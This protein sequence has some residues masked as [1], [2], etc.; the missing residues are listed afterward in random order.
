MALK[1]LSKSGIVTGQPVE[2]HHVSQSVE[3]LTGD[4]AFSLT[5]S[6]SL[7]QLGAT[8]TAVFTNASGSFSGSFQGNGSKLTDITAATAS[9]ITS[10]NIDGAVPSAS[11]ALTASLATR[12]IDADLALSAISATTAETA[13]FALNFPASPN[14]VKEEFTSSNSINVNH[15]L[16]SENVLVQ[17]YEASGSE[18]RLIN[19]S[20]VVIEDANNLRVELATNSTGYVVVGESGFL[21]SGSVQ[22]A[23][24]ASHLL[25]FIES[26]SFATTASFAEFARSVSGSIESASVAETASYAIT[27]S[28]ALNAGGAS[29]L[30]TVR[31]DFTGSTNI[32]VNHSLGTTNVFVQT[33]EDYGSEH[34]LLTPSNV[35][36]QDNNNV[37]VELASPTT[38]YIVVGESGYVTSGSIVNA[39][40]A[41][42]VANV[43]RDTLSGDGGYNVIHNLNE[44]YVLVQTYDTVNRRVI[45]PDIIESINS[46][47]T[48]IQFAATSSVAVVIKK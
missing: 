28:Y 24:T 21:V 23:I 43:Y 22:N 29:V 39:I 37:R 1:V 33:Y 35:I 38:G 19:P 13:S 11:F 6:G 32:A 26:A 41:S 45:I 44:D 31:Q 2:A 14:T 47:T 4:G 9:Y 10:S 8:S 46:N 7:T 40:T 25:G 36:I 5:I 15:L 3:A 17:V 42:F 18:H 20:Q 30:D 48:R 16:N 27:A 12:A 34:R